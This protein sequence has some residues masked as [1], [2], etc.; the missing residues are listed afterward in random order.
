[1]NWKGCEKKLL[2]P[3][4]R[5]TVLT[6]FHEG[7]WYSSGP[8]TYR[9]K[10]MIEVCDL[11]VKLYIMCSVR[12]ISSNLYKAAL[13]KYEHTVNMVLNTLVYYWYCQ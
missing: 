3:N 4:L 6:Y 1:M 13:L 12:L 9:I 11:T 2:L 5:G 7:L 8:G 10:S